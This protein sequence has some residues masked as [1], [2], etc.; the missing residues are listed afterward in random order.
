M[1]R[2]LYVSTGL[3]EH[4][5]NTQTLCWL[6]MP[7]VVNTMCLLAK[8]TFRSP[9]HVVKPLRPLPDSFPFILICSGDDSRLHSV[10]IL[11]FM[12]RSDPW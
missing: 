5:E 7:G 3:N 8:M 2:H 1:W 11:S 10:M 4:A 6:H 9:K 12:L